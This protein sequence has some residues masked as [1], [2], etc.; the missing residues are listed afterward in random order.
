MPSFKNVFQKFGFKLL[1]GANSGSLLG[2]AE[3]SFT[4]DPQAA[5][6]S[7]SEESFLQE[8]IQTSTLQVYQQTL[9][10][11]IL[12]DS[13]KQATGVSVT[14]AG[15]DYML[16]VRNEII[17]SA[18]PVSLFFTGGSVLYKAHMP[19]FRSPQMLMVSGIGPAAILE[20]LGIPVL[21]DLKG[22]GQNLH[23]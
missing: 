4:I 2:Y 15:K 5:T 20:S 21:S 3:L 22:V 6:R 10:N 23:V 14:T 18:G 11:K 7:S 9:A 13:N 16:S 19:Q 1:P 8:A 17:L 12:F